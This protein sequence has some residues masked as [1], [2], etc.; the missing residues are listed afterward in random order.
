MN[1][2]K[3]MI[4]IYQS[5]PEKKHVLKQPYPGLRPFQKH[6]SEIFCGREKQINELINRLNRNRFIAI[7]GPS[8]SGKSS[9]INAG[10]IPKIENDVFNII[11]VRPKFSPMQSLAEGL[12]HCF[13]TDNQNNTFDEIKHTILSSFFGLID[14][15]KT[16]KELCD[17]FLLVVDQFEE[18]FRYIPRADE[19]NEAA[20]FVYLL[21]ESILQTEIPLYIIISMRSDNIGECM[22]FYDL[23]ELITNNIF[24]IP[25]LYRKQYREII[26]GPLSHRLFSDKATITDK[27]TNK[28]LNDLSDRKDQL[29]ILQHALW[30]MW[31][32]QTNC[33]KI[34]FNKELYN[35]I[36]ELSGCL[37]N[38]ANKHYNHLDDHEKKI[39]KKLFKS[40]INAESYRED[41]RRPMID[42]DT[43]SKE[44]AENINDIQMMIQKFSNE[45]FFFIKQYQKDH[46]IP[47]FN[48]NEIEDDNAVM[49]EI[50]HESIIRQWKKLNGWMSEEVDNRKSFEF[51][52]EKVLHLRLQNLKNRIASE[53]VHS[54]NDDDERNACFLLKTNYLT[55]DDRLLVRTAFN[56]SDSTKISSD[57]L[58]R[59]V[60]FTDK[61]KLDDYI[62]LKVKQWENNKVPNKYWARRYNQTTTDHAIKDILFND[63]EKFIKHNLRLQIKEKTKKNRKIISAFSVL[64]FIVICLSLLSYKNQKLL[65]LSFDYC[66]LQSTI[67]IKLN[68]YCEADTLIKKTNGIYAKVSISQQFS[69]DL[70]Q[71]HINAQTIQPMNENKIHLKNGT[72]SCQC[73]LISDRSTFIAGTNTGEILWVD[74]TKN[75]IVQRKEGHKNSITQLAA[76][77]DKQWFVSVSNDGVIRQWTAEKGKLIKEWHYVKDKATLDPID[78]QLFNGY[79]NKQ[80]SVVFANDKTA[81]FL[82]SM[83]ND[84]QYIAYGSNRAIIIRDIQHNE[85]IVKTPIYAESSINDIALSHLNGHLVLAI[86]DNNDLYLWKGGNKTLFSQTTDT[87]RDIVFSNSG[88]I[89]GITSHQIFRFNNN[90]A[91]EI[92]RLSDDITQLFVDKNNNI[93]AVTQEKNISVINDKNDYYKT[94]DKHHFPITGI[95]ETKNNYISIDTQGAI[96]SW[97][98]DAQLWYRK[99]LNNAI[100]S[101]ALSADT[102]KLFV[103]GTNGHLKTLTCQKLQIIN[104]QAFEDSIKKIVTSKD[105]EHIAII[106][107][108]KIWVVDHHN[109]KLLYEVIVKNFEQICMVPYKN[110]LL[111]LHDNGTITLF[112]KAF[113]QTLA[114]KKLHQDILSERMI[115]LDI[116]PDGTQLILGSSSGYLYIVSYPE[117]NVIQSIQMTTDALKHVAFDKTGKRILVINNKDEIATINQKALQ[118]I[119]RHKF[120]DHQDKMLTAGLLHGN[121]HIVSVDQ[122]RKVHFW[123][124]STKSELFHIDLPVEPVR[125]RD[126][127]VDFVYHCDNYQRCIFTVALINNTVVQYV[128]RVDVL[129]Q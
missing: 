49:V 57:Q 91:Y 106:M 84:G 13:K 23:S 11:E 129:E 94:F 29:P 120:I 124:L 45:D 76:S 35:N 107:D 122:G 126:P 109:G 92:Y 43:I 14:Y 74:M 24:L 42:I 116:H 70:L 127:V 61:D 48:T 52:L 5:R 8:G 81:S 44:T 9:L 123:D 55:D 59:S 96:Q 28:L 21:E 83:S 65:E 53:S 80:A 7:V 62:L 121:K 38:D 66:L 73:G 25:K 111:T 39:C 37:N 82:F 87:I 33:K 86:A 15:L 72:I 114:I 85:M 77:P 41:N 128:Y 56:I 51:I 54:I 90:F 60:D 112:T 36:G 97:I 3:H 113:S 117:L 32:Q 119:V 19:D 12:Y 2:H 102:N 118:K 20:S 69:K 89:F 50:C 1:S 18:I 108:K 16:K 46:L 17:K 10:L 58:C 78:T 64:F 98:P 75:K 68:K 6:E 99:R 115:A 100:S 101:I 34:E 105:N 95:I 125:D 103:A 88:E 71:W 93:L 67:N 40:L 63:V 110:E 79:D 22:K 26:T 31:N 104:E 47:A 30:R 4:N 27:L